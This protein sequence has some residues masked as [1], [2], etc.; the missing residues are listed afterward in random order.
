MDSAYIGEIRLVGFNFA[1]VGWALCTGQEMPIMQNA[2][3]FSLLGTTY[4]GDGERTFKLPKLPQA[5]P[6][7]PSGTYIICLQGIFPPR[8]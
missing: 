4:G 1:P 6:A 5:Q 3:L 8:N 7:T 2:A